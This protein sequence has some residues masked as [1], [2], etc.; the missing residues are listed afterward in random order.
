VRGK[1]V[2]L[3]INT[4]FVGDTILQQEFMRLAREIPLTTQEAS[5]QVRVRQLRKAAEEIVIRRTVLRQMAVQRGLHISTREMDAERIRRMGSSACGARANEALETELL[6]ERL[7]M[8][9]T[10]HVPRPGRA[11]VESFYRANQAQ[12]YLP[13]RV[14]AAHIIKNIYSADDVSPVQA[15][16]LQAESEL[17]MGK[18]FAQ[19]ADR[20]SDCRGGG[21]AIGWV[22]R[23]EMVEEF[24][25]VIFSLKTGG[26]SGIF[27]TVFG[28]HL[29]TVLDRKDTGV[30]RL[31]EVRREIAHQLFEARRHAVIDAAVAKALQDS[32][33]SVVPEPQRTVESTKETRR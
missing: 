15:V 20:Y 6:I 31:E 19:V 8:V 7:Y 16:L 11:E 33:I 25:E 10:K 28:V 9:L 13:E 23:G 17:A 5:S 26:R 30:Q 1:S 29:A 14:F 4:E 22:A 2:G 3:S 32:R 21:G 18:P 24:D 12:F 27:R